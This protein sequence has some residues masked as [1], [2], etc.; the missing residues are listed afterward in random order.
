MRKLMFKISKFAPAVLVA[1]GVLVA[2]EARAQRECEKPKEETG[3]VCEVAVCL[4]LQDQVDLNCKA[5]P[6]P[7]GCYKVFGCAERQAM[8]QRWLDCRQSRI[9]IRTT[10]W[11]LGDP[12]GHD[13]QVA[14]I[15]V[16]L[17][18]CER[19]IQ[20]KITNGGCNDPCPQN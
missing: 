1:A 8:K 5:Q 18:Q 9:N 12:G 20:E 2:G 15:D 14:Q 3:R 6:A 19:A 17:A 10:C 13:T 16:V 7:K 11:P 4:A